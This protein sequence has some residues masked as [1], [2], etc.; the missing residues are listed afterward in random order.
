MSRQRSQ[1]TSPLLQLGEVRGSLGHG[2]QGIRRGQGGLGQV[3]QGTR[4]RFRGFVPPALEHAPHL[5]D[6]AG[7]GQPHFTRRP[8]DAGLKLVPGL[9]PT[10]VLKPRRQQVT[11]QIDGLSGG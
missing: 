10:R 5:A 3:G 9:Q 2:S 6:R 11:A 7:A 1:G 4:Q 8:V